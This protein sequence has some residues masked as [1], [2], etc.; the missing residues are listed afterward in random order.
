[1]KDLDKDYIYDLSDLN[2]EER[3]ELSEYLS[4]IDEDFKQLKVDFIE[5]YEDFI[6]FKNNE[7]HWHTLDGLKYFNGIQINAK[8]LFAPKVNIINPTESVNIQEWKEYFKTQ[9]EAIKS[10]L[11]VNMNDL[12]DSLNYM[13]EQ[14]NSKQCTSGEQDL[15]CN[16]DFVEFEHFINS[17]F[18]QK[19]KYKFQHVE[20]NKIND[21][22]DL[23]F[24]KEKK[25]GLIKVKRITYFYSVNDD[26]TDK[27]LDNVKISVIKF[28]EECEK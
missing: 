11:G 18:I 28:L 26:I 6:A 10:A 4:L 13:K 14:F 17:D 5:P 20:V 8:T 3:T 19:L 25:N 24:F 27:Y 21:S 22:I 16:I 9:Q 23:V 12:I 2:K 1:M 15:K 7:W